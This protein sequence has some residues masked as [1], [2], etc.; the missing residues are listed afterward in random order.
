GLAEKIP[1]DAA[2][3]ADGEV[4]IGRGFTER[5][6][7][8]GVPNILPTSGIAQETPVFLEALVEVRRPGSGL[9]PNRDGDDGQDGENGIS[10]RPA[11]A[12]WRRRRDEGHYGIVKCRAGV[13]YPSS[14]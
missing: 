12:A 7:L 8:P 9:S 3:T 5:D 11:E 6:E 13:R 14:Q 4:G 10:G 2:F 1:A